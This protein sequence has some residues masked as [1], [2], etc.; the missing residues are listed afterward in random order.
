MC[1]QE[2]NQVK[3]AK[4]N[5]FCVHCIVF[6]WTLYWT[7]GGLVHFILKVMKVSQSP[8]SPLPLINHGKAMVLC[9]FVLCIYWICARWIIGH[10]AWKC[11]IDGFRSNGVTPLMFWDDKEGHSTYMF[12]EKPPFCSILCSVAVWCY[13]TPVAGS[14]SLLAS[15]F[16][17][18][19]CRGPH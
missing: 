10:L 7:Q 19:A 4:I 9:V 16:S 14:S 1:K 17:L 11:L 6:N 3:H 12:L 2:L 8:L 5:M 18:L 15:T 13:S